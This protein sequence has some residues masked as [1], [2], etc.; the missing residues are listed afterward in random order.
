ML[1]REYERTLQHVAM[2]LSTCIMLKSVNASLNIFLG[3]V[4]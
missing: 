4:D 2:T 3:K 1:A